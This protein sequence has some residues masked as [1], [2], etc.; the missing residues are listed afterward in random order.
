M[1]E[2]IKTSLGRKN[3]PYQGQK[4]SENLY[5]TTWKAITTYISK[6]VNSSTLHELIAL[7]KNLMTLENLLKPTGQSAGNYEFGHIYWRNP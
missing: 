4:E 6:E 3:C 2:E 7:R 1:N 5:Y